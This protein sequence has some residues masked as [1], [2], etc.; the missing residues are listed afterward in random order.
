M[1]FFG[2]SPYKVAFA[3]IPIHILAAI[4]PHGVEVRT[5]KK[6]GIDWDNRDPREQ[7]RKIKEEK[8]IDPEVLDKIS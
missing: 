5:A 2:L 1:S 3:A 7:L 4:I 8:K 6:A